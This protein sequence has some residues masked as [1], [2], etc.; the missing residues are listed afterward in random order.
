[1]YLT[2]SCIDRIGP[3]SSFKFTLAL[4]GFDAGILTDADNPAWPYKKSYAAVRSADKATTTPERWMRESILWYSRVLVEKLGAERF[5]A[6]VSAFD[7]GNADVSGEPGQ[8]NGMTHSWLNTSLLIS[9][10]DW[11][12]ERTAEAIREAIANGCVDNYLSKPLKTADEV[13]HRAI[14]SFLYDW[15]TSEEGSAYEV[16]V[17]DQPELGQPTPRNGSGRFDVA[18]VGAGPAGLAA[19]VYGSSEGLET[20]VIERGAIGGQAGSSS[21]IRNYL[22]FARGIGGAELAR[23]AYEQ[24]WI[25]GTR[26]LIALVL[27]LMAFV[28]P[29]AALV[30]E[31][32]DV[33]PDRI[34]R[35]RAFVRGS[36]PPASAPELS[37]LSEWLADKGLAEGSPILM[38]KS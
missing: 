24:A 21:M 11:G 37:H 13:F 12:Y 25:F 28:A 35:Q 8:D 19:A 27:T 6:Y 22:G 3:A 17:R 10:A 4:M 38:H 20:I 23:Q 16:T 18:I 2:P 7:Y 14:S 33:A 5:A 31:L 36:L 15:T 29:V 26:F 30:V 1:M 34:E 9:P 32:D